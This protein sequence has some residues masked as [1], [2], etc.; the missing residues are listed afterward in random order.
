MQSG[1]SNVGLRLRKLRSQKQITVADKQLLK[2]STSESSSGFL[3]KVNARDNCSCTIF[4]DVLEKLAWRFAH[5][6]LAI[7]VR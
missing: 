1:D 3:F 4:Q 6:L 7:F 2:L 5:Q